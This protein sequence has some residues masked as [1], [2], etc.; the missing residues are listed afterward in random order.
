MQP[1]ELD[2]VEAARLPDESLLVQIAQRNTHALAALYDRHAQTVYNLI[3]R[4][5]RDQASADELLQDTFWQVWQKA[6]DYQMGNAVA[7]L[8]RIARN[9]SLDWLR[10]QKSR[11]QPLMSLDESLAETSHPPSS[12]S[13]EQTV[14]QS[15]QQER[16]QQALAGLPLEQRQCLELAFFE[17]MSQ[18]QIADFTQTPLGTVKTRIHMALEKL[19]RT[20]VAVGFVARENE[21]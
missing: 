5:V 17:G 2:A 19:E 6:G 14:T 7:W 9:K 3:V 11:P 16:I 10:R 8:Y 13:V 20:L 4:I 15:W 21:R 18:R 1:V 12:S